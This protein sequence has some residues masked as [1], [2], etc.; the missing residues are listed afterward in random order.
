MLSK[1]F[2]RIGKHHTNNCE[3]SVGSY[4]IGENRQLIL[5]SDGCSMGNES[6]FASALFNKILREIAKEEFYKEFGKKHQ[7]SLEDLLYSVCSRLFSRVKQVSV[8][9]NLSTTDLLA[10]IIICVIDAQSNQFEAIVIGDGL[11]AVDN[12]LY[13]YDQN[14]KPD[15]LGYHVEEEFDL[16]YK[17]Q[18]QKM[19]GRVE[20]CIAIATDGIFTFSNDV[21]ELINHEKQEAIINTLLVDSSDLTDKELQNKM[22]QLLQDAGLSCN[23]DLAIAKVLL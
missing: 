4:Q 23:D 5:V 9:T 10:T 13:E 18:Q 17:E 14:N 19:S 20:K 1:T 16:W 15:Y 7:E 8:T 3:D 22:D 21:D 2:K 6:H 11:L 12:K